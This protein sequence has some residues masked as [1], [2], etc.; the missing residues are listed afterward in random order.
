M[1]KS[2]TE[3]K[4]PNTHEGAK[5]CFSEAISKY[6][7]SYVEGFLQKNLEM[8]QFFYENV[9]EHLYRKWAV[10]NRLFLNTLNNLPVAELCFATD[11]LQ[12]PNM[13]VSIGA[14]PIFHGMFNQIKQEYVYARYQ[15]YSSLQFQDEVHYADKD[16]YLTRIS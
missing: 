14:K 9:E 4:D 6:A 15:Y 12:L 11:A 7:Q 3:C 2:A 8:P 5:K 10:E 16:T 1:L 13:V